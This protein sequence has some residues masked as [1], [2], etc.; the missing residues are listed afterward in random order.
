M[1]ELPAFNT[2]SATDRAAGAVAPAFSLSTALRLAFNAIDPVAFPGVATEGER[3]YPGISYQG[4]RTISPE[5]A[6]M[7]PIGTPIMFPITFKSGSYQRYTRDGKVEQVGLGDYRLPLT[8]MAEFSRQKEMTTT[9]TVASQGTVKEVYGHA[10][11]D[12]KL[13][14]FLLDEAKQPNGAT[15]LAAQR[16]RLLAYERLADSVEVKGD[17]FTAFG[18]YRLTIL[19]VQFG[20]MP[21]KP[22]LMPFQLSC[23]SD[24]PL[25][26]LVE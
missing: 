1:T 13:S 3:S 2:S 8:C 9:K 4:I 11:W 15:T 10:D 14:G 22:G 26:L 25:E 19:G 7:S 16:E 24:E 23:L 12:V 20:Q 17:L 18:I 6:E 21:G 5:Q